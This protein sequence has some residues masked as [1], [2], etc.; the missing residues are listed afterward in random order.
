MSLMLHHNHSQLI[1]TLIDCANSCE[2]CAAECLG[3]KDIAMMRDCIRLDR[4]CSDICHMAANLLIRESVIGHQFL[5]L[6][7]E[8]CQLCGNE[9]GKHAHL[10]HCK[11]CAASCLKCAVACHA[12]HEP[13][14]QK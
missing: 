5:L 7:E 14:T 1:Q 6:C 12:H 9:C 11:A 10:D 13:I 2:Q 4:D 8:I 3:E